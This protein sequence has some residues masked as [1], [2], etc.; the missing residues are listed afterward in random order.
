MQ[1]LLII[2]LALVLALD[3]NGYRIKLVHDCRTIRRFLFDE[4]SK[5]EKDSPVILIND[6]TRES[7]YVKNAIPSVI[8]A[9]GGEGLALKD[10]QIDDFKRQIHPDESQNDVIRAQQTI[11]QKF[12]AIN[13]EDKK[14]KISN[15][16]SQI[17][18]PL[19]AAKKASPNN[20][21][22]EFI[23]LAF[24]RVSLIAVLSFCLRQFMKQWIVVN[25]W[26][27]FLSSML[28]YGTI[29][30][31]AGIVN[32]ATNKLAVTMMFYPIKFIG[33]D[34]FKTLHIG[35]SGVSYRF[36]LKLC[37]ESLTEYSVCVQV[38]SLAGR[39]SFRRR[40]R[41]WVKDALVYDFYLFCTL[42]ITLCAFLY[43]YILKA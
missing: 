10:V 30:L 17:Q 11:S 33:V 28:L 20:N 41:R 22:F 43:I 6:K 35:N 5:K 26:S 27:K 19:L 8:K 25:A 13:N 37:M 34:L 38:R 16:V 23:K 15:I 42:F 4:E 21:F 7:F 12:I 40:R 31:V 36:T 3:I 1:L 39:V 2:S 32:M 14:A 29:P 18:V 24:K 9:V